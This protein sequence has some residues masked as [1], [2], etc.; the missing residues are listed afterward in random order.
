MSDHTRTR[1]RAA[2]LDTLSPH[3]SLEKF[4]AAVDAVMREVNAPVV[5]ALSANQSHDLADCY[6]TPHIGIDRSGVRRVCARLEA[7]PSER[8]MMDPDL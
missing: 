8:H 7:W 5:D 4:E 1:I 2:L 6:P 3:C